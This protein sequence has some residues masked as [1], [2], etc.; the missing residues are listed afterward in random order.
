[1]AIVFGSQ[2]FY[3]GMALIEYWKEG[4]TGELYQPH[5]KD[6]GGLI[7]DVDPYGDVRNPEDGKWDTDIIRE[8]KT[9]QIQ[10][11]DEK[12]PA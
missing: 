8:C 3:T 9:N 7:S 10:F 11:E 1:M 4:G 5:K 12:F 2:I 6:L